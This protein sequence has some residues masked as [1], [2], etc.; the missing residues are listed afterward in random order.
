MI[1][2]GLPDRYLHIHSVFCEGSKMSVFPW[3][4]LCQCSRGHLYISVHMLILRVPMAISMSVFPWSSLCQ[5]SRG[6]L[7]V[8][9]HICDHVYLCQCS[10][11]HVHVRHCANHLP[12][13]MLFSLMQFSGRAS[14]SMEEEGAVGRQLSRYQGQ[15]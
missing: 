4:P 7:Y 10:H 6:H 8:S 9:V 12:A 14:S 2:L 1:S 15:E 11:G 13:W 3:S 5:C